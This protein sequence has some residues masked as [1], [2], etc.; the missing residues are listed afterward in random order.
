MAATWAE[1]ERLL[2]CRGAVRV[3]I[4]GSTAH[5]ARDCGK[6]GPRYFASLDLL[7]IIS[8]PCARCLGLLSERKSYY[9]QDDDGVLTLRSSV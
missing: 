1:A 7:R 6:P 3:A 4:S 8:Q 9:I 5:M 2:G